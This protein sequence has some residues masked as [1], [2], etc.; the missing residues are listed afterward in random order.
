[1]RHMARLTDLTTLHIV[2]YLAGT[3]VF[4][5]LHKPTIT[6]T[7][8]PFMCLVTVFIQHKC[9]LNMYVCVCIGF[10]VLIYLLIVKH[11]THSPTIHF[12]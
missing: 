8:T 7:I 3:P 9:I 12:Y 1:M 2:S 4:T 5:S 10:I 6:L 11:R